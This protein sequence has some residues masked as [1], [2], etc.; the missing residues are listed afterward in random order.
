[1]SSPPLFRS[2][3]VDIFHAHFRCTES[4]CELYSLA[5]KT[6]S[7]VC[8]ANLEILPSSGFG[9]IKLLCNLSNFLAI[10]PHQSQSK[11][12]AFTKEEMS[13]KCNTDVTFLSG[14][15]ALDSSAADWL[16]LF[17]LGWSSSKGDWIIDDADSTV[18]SGYLHV[19][20]IGKDIHDEVVKKRKSLK[21][22][23]QN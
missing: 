10:A 18:N 5:P 15:L 8:V 20:G 2:K 21:L 19:D 9:Y 1:M 14:P 23:Y 3:P 16:T 12:W 6:H 13:A 22:N 11:D 17:A 4:M 7:P